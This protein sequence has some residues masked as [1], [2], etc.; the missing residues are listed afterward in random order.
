ML[1]LYRYLPEQT[2]TGARVAHR[3]RRRKAVPFVDDQADWH[4]ETLDGAGH[5]SGRGDLQGLPHC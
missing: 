4:Q 2:V 1:F 5:G 3:P